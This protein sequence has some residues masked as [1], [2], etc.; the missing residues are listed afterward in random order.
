MRMRGHSR[1]LLRQ[2]FVTQPTGRI[3]AR[4]VDTTLA[5]W[6]QMAEEMVYVQIN[7]CGSLCLRSYVFP[8]V[9]HYSAVDYPS[10]MN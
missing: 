3:G 6:V 7:D 9:R 8:A 5:L 4:L 10:L 1:S 2:V